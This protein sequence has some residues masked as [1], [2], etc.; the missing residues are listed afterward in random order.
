MQSILKKSKNDGIR[1]VNSVPNLKHDNTGSKFKLKS[2]NEEMKESIESSS[3]NNNY[4][5]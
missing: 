1:K 3:R 5:D 2:I 4:K